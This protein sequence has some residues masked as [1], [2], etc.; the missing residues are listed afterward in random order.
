MHPVELAGIS[1]VA[2]LMRGR[3]EEFQ[4]GARANCPAGPEGP[5]WGTPEPGASREVARLPTSIFCT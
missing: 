2:A 1:D 4:A 3:P 5:S